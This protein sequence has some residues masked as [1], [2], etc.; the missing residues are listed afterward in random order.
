MRRK[1]SIGVH[2]GDPPFRRDERR[3]DLA[4]AF[5]VSQQRERRIGRSRLAPVECAE[6]R[7]VERAP[8][9]AQAIGA[10]WMARRGFMFEANGMSEVKRGHVNAA[11]NKKG[12]L[13]L[14][15]ARALRREMSSRAKDNAFVATPC[16]WHECDGSNIF[17]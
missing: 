13:P 16:M 6:A 14:V 7:L 15:A 11:M 12:A 17:A 5:I 2:M 9:G 4:I 8:H 10:L 3:E 1:I